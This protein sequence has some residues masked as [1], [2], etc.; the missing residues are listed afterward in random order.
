MKYLQNKTQNTLV[1]GYLEIP[2]GKYGDITDSEAESAEV[3]YAI[4]S[5]WASLHDTPPA[6]IA[7][8]EVEMVFEKP[9]VLGM[10]EFP[11]DE[12]PVAEPVEE[13]EPAVE[14]A[15]VVAEKPK[16]TRTKAS[17]SAE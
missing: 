9:S 12:A 16:S 1:V 6:D 11:K 3:I 17:K 2:K 14:E 15:V 4:R 10:D 8:E 5:K 13:V 7:F